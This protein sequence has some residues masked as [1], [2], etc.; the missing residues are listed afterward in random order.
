[1]SDTITFS[2]EQFDALMQSMADV[3]AAAKSSAAGNPTNDEA[4]QA[5]LYEAAMKL[6]YGKNGAGAMTP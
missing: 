2:K 1:M 3:Q 5:A 4:A 6:K